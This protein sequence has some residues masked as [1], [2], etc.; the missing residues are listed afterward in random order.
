M[1]QVTDRLQMLTDANIMTD[2][3]S[4]MGNTGDSTCLL[5]IPDYVTNLK[6]KKT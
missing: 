1:E 4:K 3:T 5:P 2:H 6:K